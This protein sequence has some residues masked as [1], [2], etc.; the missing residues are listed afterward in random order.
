MKKRLLKTKPVCKVT[1][2]L[3]AQAVNGAAVV[4]LVGDFN[5]WDRATTPL[6]RLKD[7]TRSIIPDLS[8]DREYQFR[9]LIDGKRW[10]NDWQADQYVSS[11]AG[12]CEN[13]VVIT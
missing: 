2:E 13:S 5:A 1:F 9:Y 11:P 7:G 12:D 6:K 8:R 3:P 4:T 10:E